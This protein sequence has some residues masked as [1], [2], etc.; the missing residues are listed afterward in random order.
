MLQA[1]RRGDMDT[2]RTLYE[3]EAAGRMQIDVWRDASARGRHDLQHAVL[4][5]HPHHSIE[6][7]L[8]HTPRKTAPG[9][10]P[11][12]NGELHRPLGTKAHP[13]LINHIKQ[14][15]YYSEK[16][17]RV[18]DENLNGKVLF[19]D[20]GH[21]GNSIVWCRHLAPTWS[22]Q[23]NAAGKPD[24]AAFSDPAAI[25]RSV[26]SRTQELYERMISAK[27]ET[28]F[29][30]LAG[31]GPFVAEQLRALAATGDTASRVMLLESG[32]HVMAIQLKVKQEAS[33]PRYVANVYDPNLTAA[34]KRVA[35][36]DL[37]RFESLRL[38]QLFAHPSVSGEY[39]KGESVAQF[40][41][42]PAGGEADIPLLQPGGDRDRR[43][44][45]PLPPLDE[46]V[47]NQLMF[48]G[49]AGTLRDIKPAFAELVQKSPYNAG[50][51]L[52][53]RIDGVTALYVA[54]M[55]GHA[56]AVHAFGELMAMV[57]PSRHAWLLSAP[58]PR[59]LPALNTGMK[60]D[61]GQ[62]VRA[63]VDCVAATALPPEKQVELLA[64][65]PSRK[66][67]TALAAA[68][69]DGCLDS[70]NAYLDGLAAHKGLGAGHK[71]ALL[72]MPGPDGRPALAH[73]L[74][75]GPPDAA[76]AL[77]GWIAR[78]DFSADDRRHLLV[79]SD[80]EGTPVLAHMLHGGTAGNVRAY[81]TAVLDSP[82]DEADKLHVL[83]AGR[84]PA[85]WQQLAAA[86]ADSAAMGAYRDAVRQSSLPPSAQERLLG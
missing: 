13:E 48:G 27:P 8:A 69:K 6:A 62:A 65:I 83:A 39:F 75:Q 17:E 38:D 36:S 71:V 64:A 37:N 84:E 54:M 50:T 10:P 56:H 53:G 66:E 70:V 80:R 41:V 16:P 76:A 43:I 47:M 18:T 20:G 29:V 81:V 59:S 15:P 23:A 4:A 51:L 61:H 28:H 45:G 77:A 25:Q 42:V 11:A 46:G 19:P 21:K 60:Q 58:G 26:P 32:S 30:P 68:M 79:A 40:V 24:Y 49:F 1:L 85:D 2:L 67:P 82:M 12:L 33:G 78:Q 35:S 44:T 72:S 22:L 34:H 52:A 3:Q 5:L 73:G 31:V 63:Y 86:H 57:S 14:F 74:L 7:K 55:R 9:E